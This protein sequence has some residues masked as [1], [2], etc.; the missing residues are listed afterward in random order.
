MITAV[1][2]ATQQSLASAVI[3][4]VMRDQPPIALARHRLQNLWYLVA[5]SCLIGALGSTIVAK[6][7]TAALGSRRCGGVFT[8]PR[9]RHM[10]T[11]T[12][13]TSTGTTGIARRPSPSVVKL[14]HSVGRLDT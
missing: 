12:K 8:E 9:G 10:R 6:S 14:P 3:W 7:R 1:A 2:P 4:R 5:A 13:E 11:R